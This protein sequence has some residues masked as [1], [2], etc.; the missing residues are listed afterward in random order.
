MK[1]IDLFFPYQ[2]ITNMDHIPAFFIAILLAKVFIDSAIEE[3]RRQSEEIAFDLMLVRSSQRIAD[4]INSE[5]LKD[6]LELFNLTS[7]DGD[8]TTNLTKDINQTFVFGQAEI[9][10]AE[11]SYR[12]VDGITEDIRAKMSNNC[13][14]RTRK[15]LVNE[16]GTVVI[17]ELGR[18]G[19]VQ[20]QSFYNN[21]T[22]LVHFG[23]LTVHSL[24]SGIF[25]EI[26]V[27]FRWPEMDHIC[28][29][30]YRLG[31]IQETYNVISKDRCKTYIQYIRD[32]ES[33]KL[34]G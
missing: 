22:R 9:K 34:V 13:Y 27:I 26:G 24:E 7:Y 19:L 17:C 4:F 16:N 5:D 33:I 18:S 28:F 25:E 2:K 11:K 23:R 31:D 20:S 6:V 8:K 21:G 1:R 10:A 32:P 3:Q 12:E 30:R 15:S 14:Q 29:T